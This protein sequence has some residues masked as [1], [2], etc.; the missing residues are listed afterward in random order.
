MKKYII[1]IIFAF[2][3]GVAVFNLIGI[4]DNSPTPKGQVIP[5]I[6]T[7]TSISQ[8]ALPQTLIV[9]K[10]NISVPIESVGKDE[11][12]LM[13]VPS[14][15]SNTAWYNLGPRPGEVG[16]SVIAG[17]V[18]TPTGAPSVFYELK[19]LQKGD[20][21]IVIDAKNQKQRFLVTDIKTFRTSS[22]P[23][24]EVFGYSNKQMLNLITCGGVWNVEKQDYS[25]R[26]VVFSEEDG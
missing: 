24:Q 3:F 6:I 17:H 25:E 9:E 5:A 20:E 16:N 22:F 21:I 18:D 23:V 8:P 4:T 15:V 19:T 13:D 7:P 2:I 14:N 10:L 11:D 1:T 12:G 26:I